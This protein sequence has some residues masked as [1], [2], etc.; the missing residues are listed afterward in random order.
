L[1]ST[2]D[3]L[4]P[5]YGEHILADLVLLLWYRVGRQSPLSAHHPRLRV[6]TRDLSPDP[7]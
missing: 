7:V 1:E 2:F 3:D 5:L 4:G 6:R